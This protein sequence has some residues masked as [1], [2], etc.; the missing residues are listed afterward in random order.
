MSRSALAIDGLALLGPARVGPLAFETP[1]LAEPE[2]EP[3][4][5]RS[6]LGVRSVAA[7]S[8]RRGVELVGSGIGLSLEYSVP[9]PEISGLPGG[10]TLAGPE[11]WYVHWPLPPEEEAHLRAAHPGLVV[12]GNAR[13]LL[14]EGEPF[15]RA[16]QGLRE[17][18]GPGAVLWAPRV[19]LPHRLA[20]LTYLGVDIL[21]STQ[22][23]I[24]AR[25]GTFFDLD[26][27]TFDRATARN[28]RSCACA[29][30]LSDPPESLEEH[31][32]LLM[33][34]EGRRVRSAVRAGRLRE[35]VEARLTAEPLSA[36]LLRYADDLLGPLLERRTPVV[37]EEQR[38]YVLGESRRRPEVVRY[39][40]RFVER[41]RP[42]E[43]K[44]IL[45]LVPCSR[46]KP[47]R[48]SR[49][50]RRFLGALEGLNGLE[51][52]HVVSVTSPLGVVPRE[53]E[54]VYPCRHYDIPV[55][56][57]WDEGE[58]AAVVAGV[59]HLIATGA[60]QRAIVHLDP[61]EYAFLGDSLP[62]RLNPVW[63]MTDHRSTSAGALQSLRSAVSDALGPDPRGPGPMRVVR[64]ELRA[65]AGVQFGRAPAD[66]LFAEPVRL[67]GRPWFQRL[68]DGA[69]TDLATWQE[70][71][72][73]FQLTVAGGARMHPV[74][75]SSVVV[76][77]D[78][79]VLGDL[80]TPGIL[81]AGPEIRTGDAVLV[82]RDGALI[83][84]GEAA[85]PADLM[86]GLARGLAVRIRHRRHSSEP[87]DQQGQDVGT[88]S[89]AGPVV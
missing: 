4:R 11:S 42:P 21:D 81:S 17:V 58:R 71:R 10:S 84:V 72:G 74:P 41:Y 27:G 3:S 39:R 46:T 87:P 62:G 15:V 14:A 29:A 55:T 44:R 43:S 51:R 69:G 36:E 37:A 34:A 50:H 89:I 78:L 40:R 8:G 32:A 47:Y 80:F 49:S 25:A 52:V 60:Y 68:T 16:L 85:L 6:S 5:D 9:T 12:L 30:C 59:G 75:E 65:L 53:L 64:E 33:Q 20:L 18:V 48:N 13:S 26:L 66:R 2:G 88:R 31:T 82:V 1:I 83:A 57:H 77:P 24:D 38:A 7:S 35:L 76:E 28:E 73:L 63:T 19:A 61:Q 22:A 56:G 54:D 23:L 67:A 79:R 86:T 45:L 70:Q